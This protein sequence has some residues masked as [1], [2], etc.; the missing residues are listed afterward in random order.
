MHHWILKYNSFESLKK[1]KYASAENTKSKKK[2]GGVIPKIEN[3]S[4]ESSLILVE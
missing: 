3:E 1:I 4:R 2:E